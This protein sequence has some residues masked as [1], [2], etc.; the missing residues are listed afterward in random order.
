MIEI[1]NPANTGRSSRRQGCASIKVN[2][3]VPASRA[4][5]SRRFG[6]HRASDR[7]ILRIL[8][9]LPLLAASVP[10][11]IHAEAPPVFD[12]SRGLVL[13]VS[14]VTM[15]DRHSVIED[16]R[17][18]V[19]GDR[20]VAV[21]QGERPPAG[22]QVDGAVRVELDQ[23]TYFER[24]VPSYLQNDEER[25]DCHDAEG[26]G[27]ASLG[28]HSLQCNRSSCAGLAGLGLLP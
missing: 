17:V 14:V 18:L 22:T 16:G 4:P 23:P 27:F 9:T 7:F 11:R 3:P 21:W 25:M 19:R 24:L 12:S 13:R 26:K 1:L 2:R 15:D 8:I 20:I 6:C 5:A 28:R 10:G